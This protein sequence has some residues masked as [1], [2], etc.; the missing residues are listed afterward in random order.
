MEGDASSTQTQVPP[1]T[2]LKSVNIA[3]QVSYIYNAMC[4]SGRNA[5][6]L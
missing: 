6:G 5:D 3:L 4:V 1:A 2:I